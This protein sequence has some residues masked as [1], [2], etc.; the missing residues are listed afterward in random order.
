MFSPHYITLEA[1]TS[2]DAIVMQ[3]S[4]KELSPEDKSKLDKE[5]KDDAQQLQ[6][7]FKEM[8]ETESIQFPVS[9]LPNFMPKPVW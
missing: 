8:G 2:K 7:I 9:K 4:I 6:Q 5:S 3:K 1:F